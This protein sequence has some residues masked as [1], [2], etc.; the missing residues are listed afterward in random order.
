MKNRLKTLRLIILPIL[1]GLAILVFPAYGGEKLVILDASMI[2]PGPL[3]AW[4]NGGALGGEFLPG[5]TAPAVETVDGRPAVTFK[6]KD[7]Y[8]RSS[9]SVPSSLAGGHAFTAA[10]WIFDP[11]TGAKKTIVSWA[12]GTERSAEFGIGRGRNAAF[13]SSH[14]QKVGFEGGVPESGRWRHAAVTFD[15]ERLRVYLDGRLNAE[16]NMELHVKPGS[17]FFVG[18]AWN[19]G[20]EAPIGPFSGSIA[21]IEIHDACL[22]PAEIW[23]LTGHEGS[24][25]AGLP[26]SPYALGKPVLPHPSAPV[27]GPDEVTFFLTADV[28]YG[29]GVSVAKALSRLID[30]MNGLPGQKWPDGVGGGIVPRP[31][32][33]GVLGDLV[34]D[35]NAAD[36]AEVWAMFTGGFGLSGEG[37]L[38][39]PV[40]E[41][42]GNHDGDPKNPVRRGIAGRNRIRPGVK[43]ISPDGLHYSWDWGGVHFVQLHL[44]PGSAGDDIV[45]PRGG[46]F[47]GEWK[48]PRHSLEFLKDDLAKSVGRSG[49]PVVLFQHYGWDEWS[50][51]W[52]SDGEREAFREAMDGYRI[53]GIFWGHSHSVQRIDW[54]GLRTWCVGSGQRD[55]EPGEF[56]AVRIR[57][58]EMIVAERRI[59]GWGSAEKITIQSQPRRRP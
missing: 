56:L 16:R 51:G 23:T 54:A 27:D 15:R 38:A 22:S 57:P 41:G 37:R 34:D 11:S 6:G 20:R 29:V 40:Y 43:N 42:A 5:K 31:R 2:D 19:P 4:V 7:D 55:P 39:F 21:T 17:A 12:A 59:G 8:L 35:G 44:Y 49:R 14:L 13:F 36:A 10:A 46:K 58:K 45:N 26:P 32:G 52:W 50:R 33:V 18:A 24:V 9:F 1:A 47:Q 48:F 53:L 25:P 3:R 28:H 30:E